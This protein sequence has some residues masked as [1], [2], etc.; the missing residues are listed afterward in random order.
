MEDVIS[1]YIK[2]NV[3]NINKRGKSTLLHTL[4]IDM[5]VLTFHRQ[6]IQ[7]LQQSFPQELDW[8]TLL[9]LLKVAIE[10]HLIVLF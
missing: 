9:E 7:Y 4:I 8:C 5:K 3:H 6:H 2:D 10:F 1:E